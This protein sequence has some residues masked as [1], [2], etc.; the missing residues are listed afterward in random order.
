MRYFIYISKKGRSIKEYFK[1]WKA[2][3]HA[4]RSYM[5]GGWNVKDVFKSEKLD[6]EDYLRDD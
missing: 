1:S 4:V 5:E 2:C 3:S 6:P